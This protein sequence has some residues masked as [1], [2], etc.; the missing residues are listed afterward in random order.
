[1]VECKEVN[2]L[3]MFSRSVSGMIE[4]RQTIEDLSRITGIKRQ[5]ISK[6]I[7]C[8]KETV[9]IIDFYK[10]IEHGMEINCTE[11]LMDRLIREGVFSKFHM[12]GR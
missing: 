9:T 7:H 4:G 12:V 1:M 5:V 3:E 6:H 11:I 8:R 2:Y 10:F